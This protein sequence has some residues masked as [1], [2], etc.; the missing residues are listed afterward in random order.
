L[1]KVHARSAYKNA[2]EKGGPYQLMS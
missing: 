2:L 1:A